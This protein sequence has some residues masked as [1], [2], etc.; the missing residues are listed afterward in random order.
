MLLQAVSEKETHAHD[1]HEQEGVDADQLVSGLRRRRQMNTQ[2][3][4]TAL[5]VSRRRGLGGA[6]KQSIWRHKRNFSLLLA[7]PVLCMF[8]ARWVRVTCDPSTRWKKLLIATLES[9]VTKP[10]KIQKRPLFSHTRS[11]ERYDRTNLQSGTRT[12]VCIALTRE[13]CRVLCVS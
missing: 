4:F 10:I 11:H 5:P 2:H 6:T 13:T 1:R 8:G 7:R 12:S 3:R 9:G